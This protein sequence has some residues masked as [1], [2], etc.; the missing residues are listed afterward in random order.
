MSIDTYFAGHQGVRA[1]R[2]R[3]FRLLLAGT[4]LVGLVAPAQFITQTFWVQD[5]FPDRQV[6]YVALFA[7]ARGLATLLFSL[8]GGAIADRFERRR[9]LLCCEVAAFGLNA[10]VAFLMLTTPFGEATI[11]G[12]VILTFLAASNTAID[13][14]TR[15][16]S[17]PAI[18]GMEDLSNA[19]SLNQIANQMAI[20]LTI[21]LASILNGFVDPGVVYAGSLIAWVG[22]L[23]LIA[24]LNYR[25]R[26]G[27]RQSGYVAA[28]WQGLRY[29][30]RDAVIYPVMTL[31]VVIQV[32]GMTGPA[33]LGVVWQTE[34]MHVSRFGF[35]LMA[36]CWGG[37]AVLGS[38]FFARRHDLAGRGST[39]CISAVVFA[40]AAVIYGHSRIIPLTAVTNLVIGFSIA[41]MAISAS[42][43]VQHTVPDDLRGRVM[44]LF[45]LTNG[46]AMVNTVSVGALAQAIGLSLVVPALAWVTLLLV[47]AVILG[48][49]TVRLVRP[50]GGAPG[51]LAPPVPVD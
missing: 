25:S 43:L 16:A 41:G 28:I 48:M 47:A 18:V 27:A 14:P 12:I 13:Q 50:L 26:G 36:L 17:V 38:I 9:V 4:A 35:A 34:V 20:P 15:T 6:L 33:N 44:G 21:P 30:R 3:D 22:I 24:L 39:L 49:P 40:V 2:H 37:G 46:L 11:A 5:A 7:G 32:I 1:L 19:I 10:L 23:P 29:A 51:T 8:I 31:F 45:P 42:S